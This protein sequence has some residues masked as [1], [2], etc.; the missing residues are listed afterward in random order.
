MYVAV[1]YVAVRVHPGWRGEPVRPLG[2]E[3]PGE[4][5]GQQQRTGSALARLRM[6]QHY[7]D[8]TLN[9]SK[10]CRLFGI[11]RNRFYRWLHRFRRE[12]GRGFPGRPHTR[13]HRTP[14]QVEALVLCVQQERQYGV[15]RLVAQP[16]PAS[17]PS[18]PSRSSRRC[19]RPCWS[20]SNG[21]RTDHGSEFW[22]DLTWHLHN[23]GSPIAGCR[24]DAPK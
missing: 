11:S 20:P 15:V 10:T 21:F 6:S 1:R 14:L 17:V 7:E 16:L 13:P 8:V 23:L 9:V 5:N 18:R 2:R 4:A 19:A 22:I 3:T 24:P 12:G